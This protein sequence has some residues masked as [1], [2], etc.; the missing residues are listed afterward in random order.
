MPTAVEAQTETRQSLPGK[1]R[2]VA[3]CGPPNVGKS[4]FFNRLTGLRQKVAN[5]PVITCN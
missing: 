5:Y 1:N 2:A 3:I 4:S